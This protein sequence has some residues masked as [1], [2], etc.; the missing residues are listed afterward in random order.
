MVSDVFSVFL[1]E[2]IE[3]IRKLVLEGTKGASYQPHIHTHIHI[4][5]KECFVTIVA[6]VEMPTSP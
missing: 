2:G 5:P 3:V 6:G 4:V 1:L